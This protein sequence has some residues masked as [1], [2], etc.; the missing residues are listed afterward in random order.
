MRSKKKLPSRKGWYCLDR[1]TVLLLLIGVG[2]HEEKLLIGVSSH[3]GILSG[4]ESGHAAPSGDCGGDEPG[5]W[6]MPGS[7][8]MAI[9]S[10]PMLSMSMSSSSTVVALGG[11]CGGDRLGQ[12]VPGSSSMCV[13]LKAASSTLLFAGGTWV[14]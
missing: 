8:S 4:G 10:K 6:N 11:D 12:N 5:P 9:S 7:T 1:G 14:E 2:G 3:E 13:S